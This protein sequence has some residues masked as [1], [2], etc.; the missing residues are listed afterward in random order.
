MLLALVFTISLAQTG[1]AGVVKDPTGAVISGATVVV[2]D[3]SGAERQTITGPDGR[4]TFDTVP[5]QAVLI[6][7]VGGFA[8]K[9]QPLSADRDLEIVLSPATLLETV[10]VTPARSEQRLGDLP[11]SVT[12]LH[13]DQIRRSPAVVAD[14]VL[15]QIP[16]FSL[17]RRTSSLSSH[18]TTQGV[19]L[20]G[21]GPS[22]VS[23][24]LV[25]V[26]NV[27]FND[28]FGGWVYWTRVPLESL[29]RVEVVDGSIS[30]LYGNYA[31]GGVIN[32]VS[33]RPTR[34]SAAV[35][36]QYGN[37]N[38]PKVDVF[39]SDV[40]GKLGLAAD[41]SAFSTDGFYIVRANERGAVDTKAGVEFRNFTVK[42][43]Y[44]P[45]TRVRA[46]FRGG[47]FREERDNGKVS[48]FTR[49]P[50]A[51]DTTWKSASGGVRIVLPD[52]SDLQARLFTDVGTFR[53][54][55]LAVPNLVTRAIG[56][57]SLRQRV[58][59]TS[60]GGMVQWSRAF[61]GRHYFSAGSDWRWVDGD[62][63][64]DALDA[65]TGTQV[66]LR[67]ISGGTQRSVGAF[68][69]D[70]FA[71]ADQITVTLAARVDSWRNYDA[72]NFETSATT[73]QPTANNRLLPDRDDTAVSPRVA[74]IYRITD[75]V[76]AWGGVS[77]GFRA[78]TLNELYRQFRV[79]AIL[80]L[81]NDQL[82]PERLVGGEAGINI[83]P[84]AN[85]TVRMTWYDN[86]VKNPVSNVTRRD[87]VNTLQR[88]NLGRTRIR[89][90][91]TDVQHRLGTSWSVSGGYLFNQAKVREFAANPALIGKF[92]PQV[93]KHRGSLQLAFS[94]PRYATLAFGIQVI[95][96]QFDD[97]LNS[98]VVP[99]ETTPGLPGY[100]L[101]DFT[102]SRA[103]GSKLEA[104]F[105]V[106][107][108]LDEEYVV[109][110]LPTTIGSP[111][112]VNAGV[113]VRLGR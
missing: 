92:L 101:L 18:P 43:D 75:R 89:G 45:A 72:H 63:N 22:G 80:T 70:I 8:P 88:Q 10:T 12:I 33:S 76:S 4:F 94:D 104:F 59:T 87:L 27:P 95:G 51:N 47:Y 93:P 98:R 79:G 86:R 36:A 5:D 82:G 90:L 35:R 108:L 55:F 34:R 29:D 44:S 73:G 24:T 111:R 68:V 42:A 17:F 102:A 85:T 52:A 30:S 109:G 48:T 62:S 103:I 21:I 78:P 28:P 96:R 2:R 6:V 60:V 9:E 31:M 3:A 25:L 56:R 7:R 74:A 61:A 66:T 20:R 64:E 106:Q 37:L 49:D 57:M 11:A 69:Q 50:E 71:P 38:S 1:V 97:D 23:R 65:V 41:A 112:L 19:S 91:Q 100:A 13:S 105:G 107:N 84:I 26:D 32:L 99:G 67:R 46:F 54:T 58:P 83:G 110:T 39:A 77:S 15:R 113:R 81:A 16:T 40:W 14:D 53:S